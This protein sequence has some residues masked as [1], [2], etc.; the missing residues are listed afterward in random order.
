FI[1]PSGPTSGH[2]TLKLVGLNHREHAKVTSG[3]ISRA[4]LNQVTTFATGYGVKKAVIIGFGV[5]PQGEYVEVGEVEV[6]GINWNT[7]C[8]RP[9]DAGVELAHRAYQWLLK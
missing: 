4:N 7:S 2:R 5:T 9:D 6:D 3:E 1:V 8:T